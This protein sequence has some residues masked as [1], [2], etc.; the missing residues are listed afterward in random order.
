M[1][2]VYVIGL[3]TAFIGACSAPARQ[4]S[5]PDR[6]A[7]Q[8]EEQKRVALDEAR[9]ARIRAEREQ[10]EAEDA[11][12]DE[13]G[14][15]RN[16]QWAS[17]RAALAEAQAAHEAQMQ[18]PA[19]VGR[20]GT[21]ERQSDIP[22]GVSAATTVLFAPNSADLS[23]DAKG[24]LDQIAKDLRGESPAHRLTIDGYTDD[25]GA[26]SSNV[27]LAQERA[28]EV[29]RYLEGKGVA[30]GRIAT[31]GMGSVHPARKDATDQSHAL[32]RRVE[33]RVQVVENPNQPR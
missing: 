18:Q 14:A 10:R 7:N 30:P 1:K 4:A 17:Q 13:R 29:A 27:R 28:I 24:T 11:R 5:A 25:V 31:R 19:R 3:S 16:A 23:V 8:A 32:N 12:R 22:G 2:F 9:E 20:V 26:E 6:A 33:I 15:E 21:A